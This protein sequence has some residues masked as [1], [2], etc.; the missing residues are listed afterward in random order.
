MYCMTK[1]VVK[2]AILNASS[3]GLT[4]DAWTSLTQQSYVTITAHCV[5]EG[6]KLLKYVLDTSEMK[7]R[8]TST[9]LLAH[10]SEKLKAFELEGVE[11]YSISKYWVS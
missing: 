10:I 7:E 5:G 2:K 1:E 8:H 11:K 4:I 6:G 9:N 3:I